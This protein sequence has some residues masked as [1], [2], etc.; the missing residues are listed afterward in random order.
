LKKIL[1]IEDEQSIADAVVHSIEREGYSATWCSLGSS[2]LEKLK[3]GDFALIVLDVG[4]PDISGFELCKKI[5]SFSN[6][7]I[8]FLTARSDEIDKIVGL[9]IG[10]D[11]YITKPFS[12]RELGTRI[13][14]VLRRYHQTNSN[15]FESLASHSSTSL[16]IDHAKMTVIYHG[17][18]LELTRY[19][20]KLV[21]LLAKSPGRVYS[22]EMLLENVWDD[23][24]SSL[25]RTVDAH[26]KSLRSKFKSVDD[27][28]DPIVT[29]RGTGYSL[30]E[31]L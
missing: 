12:P 4:L 19:E 25:D 6:I 17:Q 20:F 27:S 23:A 10:G 29:H 2:G 18:K 7:P 16:A 22:R 24:T 11:D 5:R 28:A 21:A 8:I 31:D 1:I 30:R 13:K 14:A 15:N 9:E 3:S 26:I